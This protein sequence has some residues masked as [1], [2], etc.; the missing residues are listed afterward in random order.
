MFKKGILFLLIASFVLVV[1]AGTLPKTD[2][3]PRAT[4][5][6]ELAQGVNTAAIL[7]ELS[8]LTAQM[9]Q[10]QR[11][12]AANPSLATPEN[13]AALRALAEALREIYAAIFGGAQLASSP[14]GGRVN[15]DDVDNI[16]V[17]FENDGGIEV[18]ATL[19]DG[20]V[21]TYQLSEADVQAIIDD[22]YGGNRAAYEADIQRAQNGLSVPRLTDYIAENF[23][24][25]G[26]TGSQVA[27]II[28]FRQETPPVFGGGPVEPV[29]PPSEDPV[30]GDSS[31]YPPSVDP[32]AGS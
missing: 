27:A 5:S 26:T 19:A 28:D 25:R 30:L 23:F 8:R 15:I 29:D 17:L 12:V 1:G 4:E 32:V 10:I 16:E 18:T 13:I 22:V 7:A 20:S 6:Y 11:I 31:L 14:G 21:V 3:F 2:E 24:T 9:V